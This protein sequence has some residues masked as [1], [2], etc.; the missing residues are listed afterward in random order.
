MR[1][2]AEWYKY[3]AASQLASV[4]FKALQSQNQNKNSKQKPVFVERYQQNKQFQV[5]FFEEIVL[6]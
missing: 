1:V 2:V 3:S 5:I 4:E 6:K